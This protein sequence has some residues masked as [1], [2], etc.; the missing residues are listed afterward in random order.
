MSR[1]PLRSTYLIGQWVQGDICWANA[2]RIVWTANYRDRVQRPRE[3][4][5]LQLIR[6]GRRGGVFGTVTRL[7]AVRTGFECLQRQI[8]SVLPSVQSNFGAPQTLL[9]NGHG[10]SFS[11]IKWQGREAD[12]W[13]PWSADVKKK[14]CHTS[15]PHIR[16]HGA[17]S[18]NFTYFDLVVNLHGQWR[19][20]IGL[21][22]SLTNLIH[23]TV[24][25]QWHLAHN[26]SLLHS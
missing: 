16:L 7:R 23:L 17:Y 4:W 5:A 26:S 20:Q 1:P 24:H 22:P 6:L 12:I 9:L 11:G 18:N 2:G 3:S 21:C 14:W 19:I 8:F 25:R 10:C 15:C 13:H